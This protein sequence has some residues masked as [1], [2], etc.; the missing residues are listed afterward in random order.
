M[1]LRAAMPTVASL[2][3]ERRQRDGV[4]WVNGCIKRAM[5]GEPNQFYAFEGGQVLGTPF[6]PDFDPVIDSCIR[7]SI[8]WGGKYAMVMRNP[9]PT[10]G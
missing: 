6:T 7:M 10:V 1:D 3:D 2:V 8:A 9:E 5:A 4:Q